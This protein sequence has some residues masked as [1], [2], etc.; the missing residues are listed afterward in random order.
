MY[1]LIGRYA[2]PSV[3]R[4]AIA[5]TLQRIPFELHIASP[6]LDPS[7]IVPFNPIGRVPVLVLP[8]GGRLV[9]SSAILDTLQGLVSPELRLLPDYGDERTKILQVSA[10]MSTATEKAII[11]SYEHIKRPPEKF[12]EPYH[13]ATL[14]QVRSALEM[15]EATLSDGRYCVGDTLSLADISVAVGWRFVSYAA[16]NA[17]SGL[18][19]EKIQELSQRCERMPAFLTCAPETY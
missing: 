5:M 4:V 10:I 3:R 13:A 15:V 6:L 14:A 2:S 19:L 8:D 9:E 7:A 18:S 17:A 11:G 1:K 16:S 12:H